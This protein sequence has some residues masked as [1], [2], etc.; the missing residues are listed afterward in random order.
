[1]NAE[2]AVK[3]KQLAGI[4][5]GRQVNGLLIEK[6]NN[7][8]W[9]LRGRS[10]VNLAAVNGVCSLLL[11][12]DGFYL[13]TD[14]IEK[15]RLLTEELQEGNVQVRDYP[16]YDGEAR[17][18]L[19]AALTDNCYLTD[20]Q[21][22][23][24]I[25]PLRL[26]M[27]TAEIALYKGIGADLGRVMEEVCFAVSPGLSELQVAGLLAHQCLERNLEPVV[28]L[29]AA[30][31]RVFRFRHP[32]PTARYINDYLMMVLGV[33][34]C[35]LICCITRLISFKTVP[36]ELERKRDAVALINTAAVS[37][38]R[39]G[40]VTGQIFEAMLQK[41]AATGFAEEWKLHHQG[42]LTGYNSREYKITA[43]D[44]LRVEAGQ[45]YAWNPSITGF[46]AEDTYIIGPDTNI[47]LMAT[48]NLPG[49][50]RDTGDGMA[51]TTADILVRK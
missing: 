50:T 24:A 21:V 27:S 31:E 25:K 45:V 12:H 30:D 23:A 26:K 16:W 33:R 44:T 49:I 29:V 40:A 7:I 39:P 42:G 37:Q 43:D 32:L 34:R 36:P 48:P 11:N 2:L 51:V 19:I 46:K 38:T 10:H 6:Q 9:L 15:E 14:S 18:R 13:I 35:G 17:R 1:M 5:Q 22:E 47:N 4:Y 3:L 28:N 41:Y 20:E 8:S